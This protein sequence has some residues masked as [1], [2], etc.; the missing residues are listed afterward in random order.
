MAAVSILIPAYNA[1]PFIARTLACARAQTHSDIRIIASFD[2]ST[3]NGAAMARDIAAV[4]P[5]IEIITH[6]RRLG[7]A[8]NVNFLLERSE[9]PYHFIY[10]HDDLIEPAYTA[11]LLA[12][13]EA[14]A[15]AVSA[16]CDMSHFGGSDH[17]SLGRAYLGERTHRLL[18]L[19]LAPYRGS[20]LRS[21]MRADATGEV[22]LPH[23]DSGGY[24]ANEPFL[25]KLISAGRA[26]HV[27]QALY[28]RWDKRSGGL[29]D[30]WRAIAPAEAFAR[31]KANVATALDVLL[32]NTPDPRARQALCFALYVQALPLIRTSESHGDMFRRPEELHPAFAGLTLPAHLHE[33]GDDI[34]QWAAARWP[35]VAADLARR[36]GG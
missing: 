21:L 6:D 1:E 3:D 36:A 27:P 18:T 9:T 7:W 19:M 29:T 8:G 23:A 12:A 10:F 17:I 5:R 34:A 11:T 28:A 14:D 22:R 31:L 16:H 15:N 24:W 35:D 2:L 32:A 25:I 4:D 26:L 33:F 30:G 20:P 13:L